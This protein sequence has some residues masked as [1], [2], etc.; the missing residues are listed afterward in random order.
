VLEEAWRGRPYGDL[1]GAE[2]AAATVEQRR[3]A[4]QAA[5]SRAAAARRLAE[6]EK[7]GDRRAVDH[8]RRQVTELTARAERA[9][10]TAADLVAEQQLRATMPVE[11][12]ALELRLRTARRAEQREPDWADQDELRRPVPQAG[13]RGRGHPHEPAPGRRSVDRGPG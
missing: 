5:H 11:Q 10:T 9:S 13:R 3:R 6:L 4:E 8:L 1:T 12:K 2:L 7:V